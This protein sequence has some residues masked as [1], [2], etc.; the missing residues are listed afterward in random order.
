MLIFDSMTPHGTPTNHSGKRRRSLQFHY[1]STETEILPDS[2]ERI[3][4]FG[5]DGQGLTC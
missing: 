3:R 1:C 2:E 5:G 4:I